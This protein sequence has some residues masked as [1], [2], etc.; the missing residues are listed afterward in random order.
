MQDACDR[1]WVESNPFR[2]AG[3]PKR[4]TAKTEEPWTFLD[5]AEQVALIKASPEPERDV[6]DALIGLGWRTSEAAWQR[7]SDVHLDAVDRDGKSC[8]HAIVRYS[9]GGL[10][11]KNGEPFTQYLLPRAV[12]ALRRW[13]D[14]LPSY[15]PKNP[16]GLLFPRPDGGHRS[17]GWFFGS[18]KKEG[19][20]HSPWCAW[21]KAARI[22]RDVRVYDLRHTHA[23]SLLCGWWGRKWSL[24]EI[25]GHLGH[26]SSLSTRRYAHLAR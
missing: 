24:I 13:I 12:E 18:Y 19:K 3:K 4:R 14:R 10:A 5:L 16:H 15:T 23:T 11:R 9:R 17:S 7:L 25:Q 6:V 21:L 20:R 26:L 22:K 1:G 8:P 2:L